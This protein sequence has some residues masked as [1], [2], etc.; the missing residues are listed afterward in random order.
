MSYTSPIHQSIATPIKVN[1]EVDAYINRLIKSTFAEETTTHA[2][3]TQTSV[4]ESQYQAIM[5]DVHELALN[6]QNFNSQ[7]ISIKD[8]PTK[9]QIKIDTLS[10][11]SQSLGIFTQ[12]TQVLI[13]TSQYLNQFPATDHS[14]IL[15]TLVLLQKAFEK[16]DFHNFGEES[17][18]DL[19]LANMSSFTPE[20]MQA[21]TNSYMARYELL[22][23]ENEVIRASVEFAEAKQNVENMKSQ[24]IENFYIP[25]KLGDIDHNFINANA[26]IVEKDF[27][28]QEAIETRGKI[29]IQAEQIE[30]Q[31]AVTIKN[32]IS[33]DD[34]IVVAGIVTAI[35]NQIRNIID[36]DYHEE[37][38]IIAQVDSDDNSKLSDFGGLGESLMAGAEGIVMATF[39]SGEGHSTSN[40]LDFNGHDT[41]SDAAMFNYAKGWVDFLAE[42]I[43]KL[44]YAGTF[45]ENTDINDLFSQNGVGG[46]SILSGAAAIYQGEQS[47]EVNVVDVTL[48]EGE[49][50]KYNTSDF[51]CL[52]NNC[53]VEFAFGENPPVWLTIDSSSGMISGSPQLGDTGSYN[54]EVFMTSPYGISIQSEFTVTVSP[55]DEN[56]SYYDNVLRADDIIDYAET[57][58]TEMLLVP[59]SNDFGNIGSSFGNNIDLNGNSPFGGSQYLNNY[60]DGDERTQEDMV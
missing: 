41:T 34:G 21:F 51:F 53:N 59:Q 7:K 18:N 52:P 22:N 37:A 44:M 48:Y 36:I 15:N 3:A 50:F 6:L 5:G 55:F 19:E 43:Q 1:D 33:I 17:T 42:G 38:R 58:I 35:A 23:A 16:M 12:Y 30:A 9:S 49:S 2:P 10:L 29:R 11:H 20:A 40:Y 46:V 25:Q 39:T 26:L 24:L 27:V 32:L 60:E 13:S 56:S 31:V 4:Y 45:D 14:G 8:Q 47:D 57:L 54:V 28:L